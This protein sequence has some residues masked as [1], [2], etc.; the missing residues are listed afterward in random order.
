MKDLLKHPIWESTELG[1]PLPDSIHAVSVALPTW[2]DIINYEEKI[3]ECINSL[4][5]IYPRFGLNPLLKKLSSQILHE[6]SLNNHDAWPYPNK[7]FAMKAKKYCDKYTSCKNSFIKMKGSL[8]FLITTEA[9]SN[10]ALWPSSASLSNYLVL[11][12]EYLLKKATQVKVRSS[13]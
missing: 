7:Y 2:K 1:K 8:Y 4:K 13:L 5:S 11:N 3:P 6:N 10:Y 9:A 12:T